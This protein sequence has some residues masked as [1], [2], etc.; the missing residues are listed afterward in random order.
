[1]TEHSEA[2]SPTRVMNQRC[3]VCDTVTGDPVAAGIIEVGSGPSRILFACPK[4]VR[5]HRLVPLDDQDSPTGDGR[6][7]IRP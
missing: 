1:M 4:C 3:V 2:G 5:H 7:Q 6:L